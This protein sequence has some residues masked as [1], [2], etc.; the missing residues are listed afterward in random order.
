MVI[1]LSIYLYIYVCIYIYV[2]IYVIFPTVSQPHGGL[3]NQ[4]LDFFSCN[5]RITLSAVCKTQRDSLQRNLT[6]SIVS[7]SD[8]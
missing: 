1:Y 8:S 3:S 2:Y 7:L 4:K 6:D 5:L